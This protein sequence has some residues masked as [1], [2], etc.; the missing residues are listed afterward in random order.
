MST[1]HQGFCRTTG[2]AT[3]PWGRLTRFSGSDN[4]QRDI[5]SCVRVWPRGVPPIQ[6]RDEGVPPTTGRV[7]T[8]THCRMTMLPRLCHSSIFENNARIHIDVVPYGSRIPWFVSGL[9][10]LGV[11]LFDMFTSSLNSLNNHIDFG[12]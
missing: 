5:A 1:V 2:G 3:R 11:S 10:N 6:S 4:H 12:K 9:C 7:C 8:T